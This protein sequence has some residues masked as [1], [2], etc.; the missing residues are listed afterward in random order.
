[1]IGSS[2]LMRSTTLALLVLSIAQF[3]YDHGGS[4]LIDYLDALRDY[5]N[6][7]ANA[8]VAYGQTWLAI[9]Q[10]SL[11]TAQPAA[12]AG[13]LRRTADEEF[14]HYPFRKYSSE[15]DLTPANFGIFVC[16]GRISTIGG[17]V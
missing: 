7:S 17:T 6:T 4:A 9:H 5:R 1:M 15:N 13:C 2:V 16:R 11:A 14:C 12:S 3:A 10:M 8:V